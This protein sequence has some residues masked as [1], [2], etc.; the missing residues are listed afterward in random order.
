MSLVSV[1]VPLY[2]YEKYIGWCIESIINQDYPN[3]ELIVVDDCS[4]DASCKIARKYENKNIK[5]MQLET[6]S[7]YSKAKNEGIIVSQ[8]EYIVT[9]DA[10]DML[11]KHSITPRLEALITSNAGLVHA[12]AFDVSA[13]ASLEDCYKIKKKKRSEPKIHAQT[14]LVP[15]WLHQKYGLYDENLPSRSDKEMWWRLFGKGC[16][17]KHLVLKKYI[18]NDVAYWRRHKASM[19]HRR[20]R[21]PKYH[22]KITRKLEKA[23]AMRQKEGI[24]SKN[25]R[26]LAT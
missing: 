14:V 10:D 17:G 15:R 7:G 16:A 13:D 12:R 5:V 23:F 21:N 22:K 1:I 2:N 19:M 4:T 8:G 9:L 24:T 18:K 11:T 6:N 20:R 26:M 3:Y 25:T